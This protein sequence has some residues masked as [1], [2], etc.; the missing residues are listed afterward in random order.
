MQV[1]GPNNNN[2]KRPSWIVLKGKGPPLYTGDSKKVAIIEGNNNLN[3]YL[4]DKACFL[5][6]ELS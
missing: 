5:F 2:S 4:H 6:Q 1:G 3:F